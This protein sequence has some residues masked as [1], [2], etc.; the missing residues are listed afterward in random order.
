MSKFAVR[1]L[2]QSLGEPVFSILETPV[3]MFDAMCSLCLCAD[4][5]GAPGVRY[6][7]ERVRP[8]DDSD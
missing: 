5:S 6:L 8:W 1:G 7:R 4:S 2:V 3:L